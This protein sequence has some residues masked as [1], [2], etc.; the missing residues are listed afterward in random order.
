M[1]RV[2]IGW[3]HRAPSAQRITGVD[4][5]KLPESA[6]RKGSLVVAAP[7]AVVVEGSTVLVDACTVVVQGCMVVVV[8]S[9]VVVEGSLVVVEAGGI[10]IPR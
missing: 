6:L 2:W 5:R 1:P 7:P 9:T 3:H 8:P 4:A 10:K